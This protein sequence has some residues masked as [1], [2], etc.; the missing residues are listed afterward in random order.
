MSLTLQEA[1]VIV[2]MDICNSFLT[3]VFPYK[4]IGQDTGELVLM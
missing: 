2:L 1:K 3:L 4:T